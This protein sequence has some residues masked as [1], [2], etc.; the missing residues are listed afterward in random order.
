MNGQQE[1]GP[2]MAVG[3]VLVVDDDEAYRRIVALQLRAAGCTCLTASTQGD[4]LRQLHEDD[5]IDV[6][7]LDYTMHGTGP[8]PL[9]EQLN[10]LRGKPRI[11]GHS[12][13]NRCREF[14]ALG[15][16]EFVLKPLHVG[17]FIDLLTETT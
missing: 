13:M 7:L 14:A 2:Q 5:A 3:K 9:L 11:I 8:D 1:T 15:V 4:A 16:R 12:S 10:Q 6:I 17:R